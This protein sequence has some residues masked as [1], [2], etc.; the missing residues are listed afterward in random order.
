[1]GKKYKNL[2]NSVVDINNIRDAYEKAVRGGNR[3]STSHLRFKENLDVNLKNIQKNLINETYK[4]GR[5]YQFKV[6][7]PK[8]RVINALPFRDRV[9]QHSINNIINPIFEKT[10]YIHSY[11]CRKNKGVHQGV[12]QVQSDIRRLNK[13]GSVYYLKMDFSKYFKSI[14]KNVLLK[15]IEKKI[16]DKKL[17]NLIK[18]INV[19]IES[20]IPIGNLLSQLYANIY[21]DIFDKFIKNKLQ[22]KYY[23]RYMDD[24]VILSNNKNELFELKNKLEKFIGIF[25]KLKF[26]KWQIQS[27][28]K[29]LN[30]LGYRITPKYKLVRK[31]SVIRAKRKIKRYKR[32]NDK[33]K[34]NMFLASWVGH[35]KSANSFNL[36]KFLFMEYRICRQQLRL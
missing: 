19:D 9:V 35:I 5:Y 24:T 23:Y 30:F 13:N 15:V 4:R 21:G 34:L 12:K 31:D 27:I 14:D 29:P 17:M 18:S 8:E 25:M 20:G 22:V 3:Y 33:E 36:K 11:A 6:Y 16:K 10:F 28:N 2:F 26:S 7:D 32:Y 1:M